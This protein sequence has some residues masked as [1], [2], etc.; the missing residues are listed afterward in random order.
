MKYIIAPIFPKSAH[1]LA[2]F[3]KLCKF[4]LNLDK[5]ANPIAVQRCCGMDFM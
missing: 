5:Q 4:N 2:R 1:F 3:K